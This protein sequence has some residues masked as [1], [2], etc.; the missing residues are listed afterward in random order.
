MTR[1][2]FLRP[3]AKLDIREA[4][5]WYEGERPGLGQDFLDEARKA[6]RRVHEHPLRY[7]KI[8]GETRRSLLNRFP[9][10]IL[11]VVEEDRVVVIACFHGKRDPRIWQV[12]G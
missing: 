12:R 5:D 9:F 1:P 11:Y 10:S 4:F 3:E 7:P 8:R 2:L 6:L